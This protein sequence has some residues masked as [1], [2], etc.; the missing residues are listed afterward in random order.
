[1][2]MGLARN[3]MLPLGL[4]VFV[5][6]P[7][8]LAQTPSDGEA[9]LANSGEWEAREAEATTVRLV[10]SDLP[11]QDPYVSLY[12]K[13]GIL[14]CAVSYVVTSHGCGFSAVLGPSD[15][16]NA[17]NITRG[18]RAMVIESTWPHPGIT[19]DYGIGYYNDTED[20]IDDW[21]FAADGIGTPTLRKDLWSGKVHKGWNEDV[22][23]RTVYKPLPESTQAFVL[24]VY[25]YY[26]GQYQKEA[27]NTLGPVC[28]YFLGYCTG[29]GAVLDFRFTQ[30]ATIFYNG[31]PSNLAEY[32]AVPDK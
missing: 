31:A 24:D 6:S 21:K 9:D 30:Y 20:P 10:V 29:I 23:G 14:K 17:Y 8:H 7:T 1:M 2:G 27:N 25:I 11:S 13:N 19:M 4:L 26:D 22:Q 32:S 5:L 28:R 15:F 12:I 18:H 16:G 3:G